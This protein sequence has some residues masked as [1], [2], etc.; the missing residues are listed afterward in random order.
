MESYMFVTPRELA[1]RLYNG[2]FNHSIDFTNDDEEDILVNG[3]PTGWYGI[4]ISNLYDGDCL[5]IG[6]YGAG[7]IYSRNL[8]A[9]N[10]IDQIEDAIQKFWNI[11]FGREAKRICV[12][13]RETV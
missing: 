9:D 13:R 8:N 11:E 4:Q 10:S 5:L 7:I 12:E 3:E 6:F 1:E 2:Q